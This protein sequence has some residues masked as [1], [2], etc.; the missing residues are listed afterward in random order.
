MTTPGPALVYPAG[1]DPAPLQRVAT[2]RGWASV[3][4]DS[5]GRLRRRA[6]TAV[7]IIGASLGTLFPRAR[8][9]AGDLSRWIDA[10]VIVLT[11]E[12]PHDS[13]DLA[14][15]ARLLEASRLL[16]EYFARRHRAATSSGV[17]AAIEARSG[18]WGRG[19]AAVAL[20]AR[21]LAPLVAR[22]LSAREMATEL[23]RHG[24]A[25]A[26]STVRRHLASAFEN[27]RLSRE[28]YQAAV[29][30]R[31]GFRRGGRPR[32]RRS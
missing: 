3:E 14:D 24:L 30:A 4:V 12:E 28:S 32:R 2:A 18:A 9:L 25:V 27:G 10:G 11:L 8:D 17:A 20:S 16:E 7:A 5:Y 13:S 19:L 29:A 15:R 22:G 31:G 23:R 21:E 26:A 1:T 6:G